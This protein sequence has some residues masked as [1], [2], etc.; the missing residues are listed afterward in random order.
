MLSGAAALNRCVSAGS[1]NVA[2]I[3]AEPLRRRSTVMRRHR[4][5]IL[6]RLLLIIGGITA[7]IGIGGAAG[8]VVG[9]LTAVFSRGIHIGAALFSSAI[10]ACVGA[11]AGAIG[12]FLLSLTYQITASRLA[13][14]AVGIV[15]GAMVPRCLNDGAFIGN[16]G[17]AFFLASVIAGAV[18]GYIMITVFQRMDASATSG[19]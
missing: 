11:M 12:G 13:G 19:G 16:L 4:M 14:L 8:A 2:M 15:V 18:A 6:D 3:S 5:T 17:S 10:G 7:G 1:L 9:L